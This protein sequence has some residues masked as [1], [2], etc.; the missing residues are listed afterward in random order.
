MSSRKSTVT[1]ALAD[2]NLALAATIPFAAEDEQ[3]SGR[4]HV[5]YLAADGGRFTT[6][7]TD[8]YVAARVRKPATGR[9]TDPFHLDRTHAQLLSSAL[10]FHLDV[11][12]AMPVTL[13]VTDQWPE[14]VLTVGIDLDFAFTFYDRNV[15]P[16]TIDG[17][18]AETDDDTADTGE[19]PL[20]TDRIAP[21][22]PVACLA[23]RE[24]LRWSLHGPDRQRYVRIGDWFTG[25]FMPTRPDAMAVTGR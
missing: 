1:V 23:Q 25:T 3:S 8:G 6:A 12:S 18:F 20:A 11:L 4:F 24:P 10:A 2:L 15:Q 16:A 7:A 13:T 17:I 22:L 9:L 5:L 19:T 14:R 21:F